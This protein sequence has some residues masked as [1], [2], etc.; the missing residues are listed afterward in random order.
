MKKTL[1]K[2]MLFSVIFFGTYWCASAQVYVTV[3]PLAP[4]VVQTAR[5]GPYHV[6]VGEEWNED[7][8][9]YKYSG[10]HWAAPPH[11]GDKWNQG[12]WNHDEHHGDNWVRGSWEG[13]KRK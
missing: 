3:R 12:H 13:K 6:W 5:P 9:G 4:V 1:G 10:G 11:E 8:R 2:L 7:G